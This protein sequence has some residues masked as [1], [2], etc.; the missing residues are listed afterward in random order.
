[1]SADPN[2]SV[3]GEILEIFCLTQD[4]SYSASL[5][6]CPE[7]V[8]NV[9]ACRGGRGLQDA[10]RTVPGLLNYIMLHHF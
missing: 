9:N 7:Y 2:I 6:F 5:V 1:M 8:F 10:Y 4:F 3:P